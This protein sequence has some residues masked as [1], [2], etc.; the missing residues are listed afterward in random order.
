MSRKEA[1]LVQIIGKSRITEETDAEFLLRLKTGL[2][3]ALKEMGCLSEAQY[4]YAEKRLPRQR[5]ERKC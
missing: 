1:A 5:G 4:T 2:L 3:L